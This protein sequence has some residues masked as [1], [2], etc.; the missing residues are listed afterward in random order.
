[1]K[2]LSYQCDDCGGTGVYSGFCEPKGHAVVCL[3]CSG[4]G[5]AEFTYT[6]FTKR[7]LTRGIK[8]VSLSRGK[9]I[10]LG[11]GSEGYEVSYRDFLKGKL[12]E[13]TRA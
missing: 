5:Q 11:C 9:S 8:M 12:K 6:P 13:D 3:E 10:I 4:T 7:K 2:T 1:M